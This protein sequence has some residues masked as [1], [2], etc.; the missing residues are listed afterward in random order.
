MSLAIVRD[1]APA[2]SSRHS[3]RP[4]DVG[5]IIEGLHRQNPSADPD[6]LA[7]LLVGKLLGDRELM[8]EA[9]R[10]LVEKVL[11]AAQA[12]QKRS[13]AQPGTRAR[14]ERRVADQVEVKA[15]AAKVK[16][17]LLLD[18]VVTLLSGESKQ[19][20]F[21]TGRELAELGGAYARIAEKVG[22][23]CLVGEVICESEAKALLLAPCSN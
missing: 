4:A 14:A 9:G 8:L 13:A 22:P 16:A 15:I 18:T 23:E 6:Q 20:R 7:Q 12:R 1:I 17:T 3:R 21:V 19:L 11:A 5:E 10:L 2:K